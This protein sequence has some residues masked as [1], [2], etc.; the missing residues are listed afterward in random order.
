MSVYVIHSVTEPSFE[1]IQASYITFTASN[2][3]TGT[4]DYILNVV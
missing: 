4:W 1:L 2:M 3:Y